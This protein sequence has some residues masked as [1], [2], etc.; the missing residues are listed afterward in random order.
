[1]GF[2]YVEKTDIFDNCAKF[3]VFT[4][5]L[6]YYFEQVHKGDASEKTCLGNYCFCRPMTFNFT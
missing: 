2:H 6:I 4:G 5:K 3:E 1:M